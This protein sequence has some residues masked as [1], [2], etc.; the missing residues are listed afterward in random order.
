MSDPRVPQGFLNRLNAAVY[1]AGNPTLNV[2]PSYLGKAGISL[3]FTSPATTSY[4]TMAGRV[5]SPEPYMEATLTL[6]L[7]RTQN[8]AQ[9]WKQQMESNSQIGDCTVYP[10]VGAGTSGIGVF[11]LLN[12]AIG[13]GPELPFAGQDPTYRFTLTA[14]Y[15]INQSLWGGP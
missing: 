2:T 4:P 11:N 1:F 6:E 7:L 15:D 3:R 8:L 12:A 13:D 14:Y 10:D 9:L 5:Q